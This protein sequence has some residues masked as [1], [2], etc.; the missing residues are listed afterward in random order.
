MV[1]SFLAVIAGFVAFLTVTYWFMNVFLLS[2]H[3]HLLLFA[4]AF[5]GGTIG[6]YVSALIAENA[7][8]KH[9]LALARL[10]LALVTVR[11]G[12]ESASI[13]GWMLAVT[14]VGIL[15]GASAGGYISK[16]QARATVSRVTYDEAFRVSWALL[17]PTV[18][19]SLVFQGLIDGVSQVPWGR[20]QIAA[21]LIAQ[22]VVIATIF[23]LIAGRAVAKAYRGFYFKVV[24]NDGATSASNEGTANNTLRF[25]EKLR[26]AWLFIWR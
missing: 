7:V 22:L 21:A 4:G 3:L 8:L 26:M 16:R 14:L 2:P 20:R 11:A 23:P 13:D 5:I 6:G 25:G 9:A 10:V 1:K 17:W 15:L 19:L 12:V 24:H 18:V